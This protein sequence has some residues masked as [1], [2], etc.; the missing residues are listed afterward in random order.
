MRF[1]VGLGSVMVVMAVLATW[2]WIT[3][4][5][6]TLR[7]AGDPVA[8]TTP[9]GITLQP[10]GLAQGYGDG[11][12]GTIRYIERQVALTDSAGKTL[13]TYDKDAVSG[14]ASCTGNCAASW[15]P[16]IA[17]VS[18]Q[19]IGDWSLA[20][21]GGG[22]RQWAYR[23]KPLYTSMGDKKI[24]DATGEGFEGVWHVAMARPVV[25]LPTGVVVQEVADAEG[26]VL[27]NE[28]GMTLYT[29]D[30]PTNRES[31]CLLV[32]GGCV[33]EWVPLRAAEIAAA[34]GDFSV[35]H[36]DDGISQWAYK[37]SGLYTFTGDIDPGDVNGGAVDSRRHVAMITHHFI[38]PGVQ[39]RQSL[40]RGKILT[41]ASGMT[42][43]RRDGFR[44][45]VGLHGLAHGIQSLPAFG[46]AIGTRGCD[47]ECRHVWHPFEAPAD[48]KPSGYWDIAI[49]EDDGTRQW[50]Y[51]GYALYTYDGDQAPGDMRGN[52]SYDFLIK[53]AF[54]KL[55]DEPP[56]LEQVGA[57]ALYWAFVAP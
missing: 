3:R 2:Y 11:R 38:P 46:R 44:Q 34:V 49:R 13:Y 19:P 52:D 45:E 10:L 31:A 47:A 35:I 56:N 17:S 48:A 27:V 54:S 28:A 9:P 51:K 16:A 43:Y 4:P 55:P 36:N 15:P 21:L 24:G 37:G 18:A 57:G 22:R 30:A 42:L 25:P 1:R 29:L 33:A 41:N 39:I 6:P 32:A 23:G 14:N 50:V 20:V 53:T 26:Y 12:P 5:A 8:V 40:G 7:A